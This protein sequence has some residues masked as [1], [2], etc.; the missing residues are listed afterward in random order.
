MTSTK[1]QV[2]EIKA[3]V[4]L[5]LTGL[6]IE[7]HT[8][9]SG[10]QNRSISDAEVNKKTLTNNVKTQKPQMKGME[11][12]SERMINEIE[13]SQLS[14]IEFKTMVIR[15]LNELAENYQKLQGN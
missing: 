9:N 8:T 7:V 5:D 12:A 13:S 1:Q 3:T 11:E 4:P 10:N 2:Q 15:K 6:L 14:D